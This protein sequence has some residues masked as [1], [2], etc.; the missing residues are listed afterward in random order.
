MSGTVLCDAKNLSYSF[1]SLLA[2]FQREIRGERLLK[3][4]NWASAI[5]HKNKQDHISQDPVNQNWYWNYL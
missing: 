3:L 4:T 5:F 1:W 2:E